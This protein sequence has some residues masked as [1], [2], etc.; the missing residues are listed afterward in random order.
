MLK[1]TSK[2]IFLIFATVLFFI[3]FF[4]FFSLLFFPDSSIVLEKGELLKLP[5]DYYLT[6][7]FT[8]NR[9][10]LAEIELLLRSPGI[11]KPDEV[12]AEIKDSVCSETIR[13]GK[14]E[15]SFLDSNNLYLF[16][17]PEIPDSK[18]KTYC[19]KI[20]FIPGS[21]NSKN[22]QVFT[23]ANGSARSVMTDADSH[24]T[25]N[26]QPLS[27]RPVYENES[28]WQN[29]NELNQRISQYKPW[30]LKHYYLYAISALF[31][32][33]SAVLIVVL[34]IV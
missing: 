29:I 26:S 4:K 24:E 5:P 21:A 2:K 17:F 8:A 31:I 19:L 6:Q 14:L 7:T 27:M 18:Y 10:N 32:A 9:N 16:K 1:L 20:E 33:L 11:N 34:I 15:K 30:F 25:A 22:I 23:M 12:R 28:V 3:V 13:S